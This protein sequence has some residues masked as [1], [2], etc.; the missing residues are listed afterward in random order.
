VNWIYL[1]VVRGQCLFLVNIIINLR[2]HRLAIFQ[3]LSLIPESKVIHFQNRICFI[4]LFLAFK[5]TLCNMYCIFFWYMYNSVVAYYTY[6]I[7][8]LGLVFSSLIFVVS[9]LVYLI[10]C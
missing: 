9:F 5:L 2:F 6:I 8:V 4:F 10:L 3:F 1:T 7:F